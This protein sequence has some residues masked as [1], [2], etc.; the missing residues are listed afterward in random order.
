MLVVTLRTVIVYALIIAAVRLMGKRQIGELQPG[1][2][3]TTI[4]IS[5]LASL[6][7]EETDLPL[8]SAI[9]PILIIICLEVLLSFIEI[10]SNKFSTVVSGNSK[11]VIRD[12]VIDQKQL[13][14]LRFGITDVLEALRNKDIYDINDVSY[15][16]IE[17]NGQLNAYTE[18]EYPP[19]NLILNGE[20]Q[21]DT[22][23]YSGLSD[24]WLNE[25][26]RERSIELKDVLLMQYNADGEK[27]TLVRREAL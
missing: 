11:T 22:F 21:K 12:G 23:K 13:F 24:N 19:L 4:L 20:V 5:N 2:L 18:G 10:R 14:D 27:I 25:K 16:V 26:L 1:E 7:I 8:I 9:A 17:T 15:A 6:P 3:V